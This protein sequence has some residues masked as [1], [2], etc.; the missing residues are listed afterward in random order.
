MKHKKV[1]LG[2]AVVVIVAALFLMRGQTFSIMP[3][4]TMGSI[5]RIAVTENTFT[6][7]IV[8]NPLNTQLFHGIKSG[9]ACLNCW[10][11]HEILWTQDQWWNQYSE[12]W[13]GMEGSSQDNYVMLT[14]FPAI[15]EGMTVEHDITISFTPAAGAT[16]NYICYDYK[17]ETITIDKRHGIFFKKRILFI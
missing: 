4:G 17:P 12:W 7:H 16:C 13:S 14:A 11:A 6:M 2:V 5:N 9:G 15:T 8:K 1:L 10:P 3:S